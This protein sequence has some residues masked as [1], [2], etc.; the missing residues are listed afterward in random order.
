[1]LLDQLCSPVS[2]IS[3]K[4][5]SHLW[6]SS[7]PNSPF[8]LDLGL[9]LML[10][11]SRSDALGQLWVS[12]EDVIFRYFQYVAW[13]TL[14]ELI[15]HAMHFLF[16]FMQFQACWKWTVQWRM[17]HS[18]CPS[19]ITV[20]LPMLANFF[21]F[22]LCHWTCHSETAVVGRPVFSALKWLR[23]SCSIS[24]L[25]FWHVQRCVDESV[26]AERISTQL[27][28]FGCETKAFLMPD[29]YSGSLHCYKWCKNLWAALD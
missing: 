15:E 12:M 18:V 8:S 10:W 24:A 22:N 13:E 6:C 11:A 16:I 19:N 9:V 5:H 20:M 21:C 4:D 7:A 1:M 26:W 17:W 2:L 3:N 29:S 27:R 25:L 28:W 14:R 23:S